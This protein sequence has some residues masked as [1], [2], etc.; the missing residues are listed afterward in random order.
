MNPRSTPVSQT[1]PT[2]LSQIRD[3]ASRAP[4]NP[5]PP[6]N[7]ASQSSLSGVQPGINASQPAAP[8]ATNRTP[9][10]LTGFPPGMNASQP[11]ARAPTS[12][13]PPSFGG[14]PPGMNASQPAAPAPAPTSNAPASFGGFPP[15]MNTSQSNLPAPMNF[16]GFPPGM[17]GSQA[18]P[19]GNATAPLAGFPPGLNMNQSTQPPANNNSATNVPQFSSAG[20]PSGMLTHNANNAFNDH[21]SSFRSQSNYNHNADSVSRLELEYP[22][23][24]VLIDANIPSAVAIKVNDAVERDRLG[25]NHVI[26]R[27]TFE[28]PSK[29]IAFRNSTDHLIDPHSENSRHIGIR[30]IREISPDGR[31]SPLD[32]IDRPRRSSHRNQHRRHHSQAPVDRYVDELLRTPGRT[33]FHVD[34]SNALQQILGQSLFTPQIFPT[35]PLIFPSQSNFSSVQEPI[36]YFVARALPY[37]PMRILWIIKSES[38]ADAF[39][40]VSIWRNDEIPEALLN[41]SVRNTTQSLISVPVFD[42]GRHL[43]RSRI[44]FTCLYGSNQNTSYV[45]RLLC[46]PS[47]SVEFESQIFHSIQETNRSD[48]LTNRSVPIVVVTSESI[49]NKIRNIDDIEYELSQESLPVTLSKTRETLERSGLVFL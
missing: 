32:E 19:T 39:L 15:G 7:H 48:M 38:V 5:P 45:G 30:H 10:P 13:A 16:A 20:P 1:A 47:R 37:D 44:L 31:H 14:F 26:R 49:P 42:D 35:E 24:N 4:L 40:S 25:N 11:A 6:S 9:T 23:E 12:N 2:P 18:A 29:T 43:Y 41:L 46:I 21:L 28:P 8:A 3:L 34:N 36:N 17:N 33:V 27:Y 22:I